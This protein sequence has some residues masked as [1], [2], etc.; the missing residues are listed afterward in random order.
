MLGLLRPMTNRKHVLFISPRLAIQE[1]DF[2]GSGVPYWPLEAATFAALWQ[3]SGWTAHALDLF[4]L[5]PDRLEKDNNLYWQG[6]PLS[7]ALAKQKISAEQYDWVFLYAI[8]CM[9][10]QELLRLVTTLKKQNAKRIVIFE[11]SQAVTGY[12]LS[13]TQP[14]FREA[15]ADFL[16]IGEPYAN[17]QDLLNFFNGAS[18]N[19]PTNLIPLQ[20]KNEAR[21]ER[22]TKNP[23]QTP[24]PAWDLFPYKNYWNLPYSHGPK[25]RP[26]LPMLT[27][28]GCPYPCTFC[29]VPA[30]NVQKWRARTAEDVVAEMVA[31]HKK[32]GV[33]DFQWE[34]L[35]STIDRARIQAIGRLLNEGGHDFH[36]RLVSGTKV[37]TLDLSTLDAL[38]AA[39]CD[40]ISIS[41]ESGSPR[42]LQKMKKPF[43]HA[44][45]LAMVEAMHARGIYSQACFV[46]GHPEE[47]ESD[48]QA[49][50][51]YVKKITEAGI[52]E[53]AFFIL[54]PLPGSALQ[55]AMP[56]KN[57]EEALWSF[58]P[59]HRLDYAV[60]EKWRTRLIRKFLFWKIRFHPFHFLM[61]GIHAL[62]GRPKTKMEM[63]PRR[64]L[65]IL[66]ARAHA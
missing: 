24:L 49:T 64:V 37:E 30:T 12:D 39:G 22:F 65:F 17:W 29:V 41:P 8:S 34:D 1:G 23:I 59:T 3:E 62:I 4:G 43:D 54:S 26:Y 55:N 16:L 60:L 40:Y 42:I 50:E 36:F 53:V 51:S 14:F 32:Y 20:T 25:T 10:H 31:L 35:N 28:R 19:P 44:H 63:L 61:Q 6:L 33:K 21:A 13:Q 5:A 7:E 45:A 47:E 58:S 2:L 56:Y 57:Y 52:D 9:S 48:R 27:S 11:N 66:R 15:G 38:A 18:V 46:L